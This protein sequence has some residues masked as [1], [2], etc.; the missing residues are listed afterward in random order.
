MTTLLP[1]ARTASE[2]A[3]DEATARIGAVETPVDQVW[4]PDA[5]PADM[6]PWLAWALSVDEWDA[7]WSEEAKRA[8][9]AAAIPIH[10]RKGTRAS[11]LRTLK[12]TGYGDATLIENWSALRHDGS[13]AHDGSET[14]ARDDHWA[15]YRLIL[16]RP[17]TIRQAAQVRRIL[18]ATAPARC[19]L[20]VMDFA[21]AAHLHDRRIRH[22]GVYA[23]GA[24]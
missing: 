12:V 14:H 18:D 11:I 3:L 24:S 17:V 6:L 15:E 7:N 19:H 4:R 2:E 13:A 8:S 16:Q 22:D 23:H 20:R 21:E 10:Q 9:I 1:P 5:C